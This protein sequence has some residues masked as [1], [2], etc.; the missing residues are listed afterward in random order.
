IEEAAEHIAKVEV[1]QRVIEHWERKLDD[2]FTYDILFCQLDD[3]SDWVR[4]LRDAL[5]ER[6]EYV[7]M[8][9]NIVVAGAARRTWRFKA[10]QGEFIHPGPQFVFF[11][12]D[13]QER[14]GDWIPGLRSVEVGPR[15]LDGRVFYMFGDSP[16][17][18]FGDG[19]RVRRIE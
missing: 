9:P 4:P 8:G 11:L 3:P 6:G 10:E 12:E 19:G 5:S 15:I 16:S 18:C 13:L 2:G 17:V 7:G 14:D 1:S